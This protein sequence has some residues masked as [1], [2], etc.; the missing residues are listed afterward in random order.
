MLIPFSRSQEVR[1]VIGF[2]IAAALG[3]IATLL[4]VPAITITVS[5]L[6]LQGLPAE[7]PGFNVSF[8]LPFW[9]HMLFFAV[10]W[11]VY[12]PIPYFFKEA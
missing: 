10:V 11:L 2:V 7:L 5:V 4:T 6:G 3:W 12:L 1:I 9:N 8:G